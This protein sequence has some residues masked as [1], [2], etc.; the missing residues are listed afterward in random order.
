M[1]AWGVC[2]TPPMWLTC[3][4]EKT[5]TIPN[6]LKSVGLSWTGSLAPGREAYRLAPTKARSLRR[7]RCL[8]ARFCKAADLCR[9]RRWKAR[10]HGIFQ[11]RLPFRTA[12][13]EAQAQRSI[14]WLSIRSTRRSFI[15]EPSAGS[16]R[17][18]TAASLGGICLTRGLHRV[19]AQSPSILARLMTSTLA[20]AEKAAALPLMRSA[21]TAHST[22]GQPGVA[23]WERPSLKVRTSGRLLSTRTPRA[24]NRARPYTPPTAAQTLADCGAQLIAASLGCNCTRSTTAFTM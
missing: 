22:E 13:A 2:R 9:P 8:Q 14:P 4:P 5:I 23:P 7:E 24:R 11:Y 16:P 17:Q 6:T 19:S 10:R 21:S 1:L 12:T 20:R 18:P 15:Q 3:H